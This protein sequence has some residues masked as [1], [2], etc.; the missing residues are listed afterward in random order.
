KKT[1]DAFANVSGHTLELRVDANRVNSGSGTN[2][3]A[4]LGWVP[5]SG[6][7]LANG[8]SL[9]VG[10]ADVQIRKGAAV[11]YNADLT[12]NLQNTNLTLVLRMTTAGATVTLNVHVY[13]QTGTAANQNFTTLFEHTTVDSAGLV[14]TGG[15]AALGVLNQPSGSASVV[16]DNLCA[17]D[18]T[19]GTLDDFNV[20]DGLSGW[21]IFKNQ[22]SS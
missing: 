5:T 16:F 20:A 11:L 2:A 22:N 4:V 21:H 17:F 7:L 10:M 3:H 9:I 6:A 1:S 18:L 15:N 12:S 14:G 13:R 19:N 8:Y